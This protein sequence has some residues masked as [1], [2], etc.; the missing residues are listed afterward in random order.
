MRVVGALRRAGT[1]RNP[2]N[3]KSENTRTKNQNVIFKYLKLFKMSGQ[4][5]KLTYWGIVKHLHHPVHVGG[6]VLAAAGCGRRMTVP[7][8]RD[9]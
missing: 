6:G 3:N 1:E 8:H 4:V 7:L 2:K 5:T 9:L